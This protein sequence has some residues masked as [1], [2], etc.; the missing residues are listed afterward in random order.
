MT[1]ATNYDYT[2]VKMA[3]R[4][5]HSDPVLSSILSKP[6]NEEEV[7]DVPKPHLSNQSKED[8]N[9][10]SHEE[11]KPK[12][13]MSSNEDSDNR[14]EEDYREPADESQWRKIKSLVRNATETGKSN[15]MTDQESAFLSMRKKYREKKSERS[16]S[17]RSISSSA[18][19][20][21]F[22]SIVNAAIARARLRQELS[23]RLSKLT[24]KEADFLREIVD[25]ENV[26]QQQL[27]NADYVLNTGM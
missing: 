7:E 1:L 4:Y 21:S 8:V 5:V 14:N 6:K 27:E 20:L 12:S 22:S 9:R 23:I 25:D 19:E 24:I 13:I 26:T 11:D 17:S 10:Q 3:T 15:S 18:S 2:L 16:D